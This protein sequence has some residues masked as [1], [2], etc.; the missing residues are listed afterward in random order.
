MIGIVLFSPTLHEVQAAE[1]IL[2]PVA[3][4]VIL[5]GL[6]DPDFM[7]TWPTANTMN[8]IALFGKHHYSFFVENRLQHSDAQLWREATYD[9]SGD[10]PLNGINPSTS[11]AKSTH[12]KSFSFAARYKVGVDNRAGIVLSASSPLWG[13]DK[14]ACKV[15]KK[16]NLHKT[17]D[18][19]DGKTCKSSHYGIT[20][21]GKIKDQKNGLIYI[22]IIEP[23][24]VNAPVTTNSLMIFAQGVGEWGGRC[25]C[26]DGS[27]YN[28]GDNTD[29]CDS[30]ACYG[31]NF[32]N[33]NK[34]A[35]KWSY[36]KV[37]CAGSK[38]TEAAKH[39]VTNAH[40]VG[41]W[42]GSCTCPGGSVYY[43]GDNI[44]SCGSLACIGGTPGP[45]NKYAGKWSRNK[46]YCPKLTLSKSLY[47]HNSTTLGIVDENDTASYL[48]EHLLWFVGGAGFCRSFSWM[49]AC[50]DFRCFSSV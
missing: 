11:Q 16:P 35:G 44:D 39:F 4:G 10:W 22:W 19:M 13:S 41:E 9:D 18:K 6:T 49:R 31:G 12:H 48:K 2:A 28:V 29:S 7:D 34:Y 15:S 33:C 21:R 42:G 45:C 14:I 20:V 3:A 50:G 1:A 38:A 26:P 30:L 47:D 40:D 23:H 24:V 27:V 36:N 17:W 46:V 25:T 32:G 43:V 8:A 5:N 37:I